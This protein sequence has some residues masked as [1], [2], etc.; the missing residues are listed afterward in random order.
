M[1]KV[2][3]VVDMQN[4][5]IDGALG[6]LEA[7]EIVPNIKKKIE[8]YKDL[9]YDIIFTR[10]THQENYLE[11][12]E[13]KNLP[14]KHCVKNTDGWKISEE[15]N[16]VIATHII[17]KPTFGFVDWVTYLSEFNVIEGLYDNETQEIMPEKIEIVGVCSGICVASNAL[18][19]KSLYP[20]TEITVDASCC[21]CVTPDSHKAALLTMKM[22]QINVVG[23]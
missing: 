20:D 11:T 12:T 7:R 5:F 17:D 2:L 19:L 14:V 22:C 23:E 3:I 21:A 1:K 4:D 15:L 9:G 13:G 18:I 16:T 10:D 6:T 8:E